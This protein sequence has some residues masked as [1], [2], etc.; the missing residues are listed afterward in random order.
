MFTETAAALLIIGFLAGVLF[1]QLTAVRSQEK[2]TRKLIAERRRETRQAVY[3]QA[4][5]EHHGTPY[6][7]SPL[8]QVVTDAM[9]LADNDRWS[10]KALPD[11]VTRIG[12]SR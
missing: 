12:V 8:E 2:Q 9:L 3:R 4:A 5:R 6:I 1:M 10:R 7:R 11:N